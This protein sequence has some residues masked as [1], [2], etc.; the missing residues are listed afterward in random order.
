MPG[1]EFSEIDED[2]ASRRWFTEEWIALTASSAKA[3]AP[4]PSYDGTAEDHAR[5]IIDVAIADNPIGR[6]VA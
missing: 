6:R 1:D 3:A 2:Q 4:K 5:R